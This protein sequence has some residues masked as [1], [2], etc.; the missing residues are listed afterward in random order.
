LK[1]IHL[2]SADHL[3]KKISTDKKEY[4]CKQNTM[5]SLLAIFTASTEFWNLMV[6]VS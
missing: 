5:T 6:G 2:G 3:L 1:S 4:E